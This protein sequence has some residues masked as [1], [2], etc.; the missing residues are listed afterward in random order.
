MA[1]LTALARFA[2]LKAAAL[3]GR[4][5]KPWPACRR[6]RRIRRLLSDLATKDDLNALE[7][8]LRKDMATKTDLAELKAYVSERLQQSNM[9]LLGGVGVIV[10]VATAIIKLA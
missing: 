4:W 7:V 6:T 5:R 8:A 9:M 1:A 10:A 2:S 3:T